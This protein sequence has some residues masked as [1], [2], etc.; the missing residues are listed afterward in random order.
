MTIAT[1]RLRH[2]DR[3]EAMYPMLKYHHLVVPAHRATHFQRLAILALFLQTTLLELR[4]KRAL[5][6]PQQGQ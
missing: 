3:T 6:A 5:L 4:W 2:Q 1:F